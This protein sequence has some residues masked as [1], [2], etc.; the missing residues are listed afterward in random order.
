MHVTN[1]VYKELAQ[2]LH[3]RGMEFTIQIFDV[4]KV[5]DE[6]IS[7]HSRSAAGW[8]SQYHPLNEVTKNITSF[9]N[10]HSGIN[11]ANSKLL[12]SYFYTPD[13]EKAKQ[14][15]LFYL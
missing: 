7:Q 9:S 12:R 6:Q 11:T 5:M 4:Q 8:Y 14:L 1:N 2:Y 15:Y 13:W 3:R 10:Y